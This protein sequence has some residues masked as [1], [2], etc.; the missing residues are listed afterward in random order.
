VRRSEERTWEWK[1]TEW[2]EEVTRQDNKSDLNQGTNIEE[3][4]NGL[5]FE[6]L[7]LETR[8]LRWQWPLTVVCSYIFRSHCIS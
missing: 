5:A 1:R 2:R 7:R 6:D 3:D 4:T 8:F